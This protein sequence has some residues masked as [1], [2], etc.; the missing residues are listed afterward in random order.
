MRRDKLLDPN[1]TGEDENIW[2]RGGKVKPGFH[3]TIPNCHSTGR[4][5]SGSF[6]TP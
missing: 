5:M 1:S 4:E 2:K 3:T 6:A